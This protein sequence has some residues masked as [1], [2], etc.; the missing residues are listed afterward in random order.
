MD[1]TDIIR[2]ARAKGLTLATAESCT[3]GMITAALTDVAGSSA[4]VD[5]GYVTY[6]NR[7][8][9]EMLG[10]EQATLEAVGAV[11]EE[12][13]TE[14]AQG[15]QTRADVDIAVAVTGI[16]G[17]GGS[18]HKPEG[19]VC[20]ALARRHQPTHVETIDF[21]P[22]GRDGVRIATRDH[23]LTLIWQSLTADPLG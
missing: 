2:E 18:E 19:R 6:S 22:L 7:A 21:G 17:P 11:S 3:A 4:V 23:A 14:M 5:R 20:F 13:A 9:Q 10:V 12:V 1:T 8:K 16:A 15:A